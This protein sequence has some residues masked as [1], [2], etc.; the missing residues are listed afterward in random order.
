MAG[1]IMGFIAF[2]NGDSR[3]G[4]FEVLK[5]VVP[6]LV[7]DLV[8]PLV[9]M[10]RLRFSILLAVGLLAAVA[11][12]A[13]Q[14]A[15]VFCLGAD[16]VTLFLLPAERLIPNLIAGFLSAFVS[17]PILKALGSNALIEQQ[18]AKDEEQRSKGVEELGSSKEAEEQ[19][20][21]VET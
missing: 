6:G 12:T 15:M 9:R 16:N 11:R 21:S 14:F 4:I 1:G 2:L 19:K 5:H 17:Y 3:Y 7:V 18:N 8:W 20:S 10:F 13:T